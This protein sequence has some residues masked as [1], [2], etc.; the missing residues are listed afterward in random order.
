ME[1]SRLIEMVSIL[2]ILL[3]ALNCIVWHSVHT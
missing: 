3:E 1:T 2:S